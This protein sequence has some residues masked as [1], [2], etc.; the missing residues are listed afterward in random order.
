MRFV[1]DPVMEAG[2]DLS[3]NPR[4]RWILSTAEAVRACELLETYR[5][6]LGVNSAGAARL[7]RFAQQLIPAAYWQEL[8]SLAE[9]TGT[10]LDDVV[11]C[12]L[13]YDALKA[14]LD[15]TGRQLPGCTAFACEHPDG[16][17]LHA[18]NLDWWSDGTSLS[19][20]TTLTQFEN[21]PAGGFVTV[22]WPGFNG[23]FSGI[24]PGRFAVTL[25]AVLSFDPPVPAVPVVYLLR[26]VL[27]T[28]RDYNEALVRLSETPIP[29]DCLLLLSGVRRGE[30]AVIERTPTRSAIRKAANGSVYVTNDYI[31]LETRASSGD[32]AATSC[33]RRERIESLVRTRLPLDAAACVE[34]LSDDGVKM[35]I[36]MQQMVFCAATGSVVCIP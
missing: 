34:Y 18:R 7:T 16:S 32:L 14:V 12:N 33:G 10:A 15:D 2:V 4:S 24:A 26:Q 1:R 22:G 17:I 31:A 27:E 35:K 11:L 19:S 23:V 13:Y 25:N 3:R 36:T 21:A 5:A 8:E 29:C 9:Q 28:A 20:Y 6:D 30:L